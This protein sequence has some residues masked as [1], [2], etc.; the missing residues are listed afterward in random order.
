[1]IR[2]VLIDALPTIFALMLSGLYSVIDGLFIGRATGDIGLSAINIAWPITA[3]ITATGTGIGTGGSVLISNFSGKGLEKEKDETFCTTLSLLLISAISLMIV[4]LLTYKPLVSILGATGAVYNET[5]KYSGVIIA[6]SLLQI[7]GAGLL[8]MLRNMNMPFYAMCSMT[9]GMVVNIFVNYILIFKV[10]LGIEGAAYGTAIAQFVVL[11]LSFYFLYIK[12]KKRIDLNFN[13]SIASNILKIAVAAF[14][15]SIG[16]SIALI[17]TNKQCYLYGGNELL[18]CYAVISYIVFPVQFMLSG[19][20]DGTQPL[21]SY[22]YGA[23]RNE[24]LHQV[25]KI[26]I[27]LSIVISL[28]SFCLSSFMADSI[29]RWFG[30][31]LEAQKYFKEGMII[32]GISFF[33]LGF[34]KCKISFYN[35]TLQTKRATSLTYLECFFISPLCLLIL[36]YFIGISGIWITLTITAIIMLGIDKIFNIRKL[37]RDPKRCIEF[38]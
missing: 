14:G 19:V 17:F 13:I 30:L 29:G 9:V 22:F 12:G 23:N 32:S 36:P 34:M 3:V 10:G 6:S 28:L 20:G 4:L 1:M 27:A 8:P 24:E 26:A 5:I 16:P 31:S 21:L 38:N 15:I 2:R 25:Q 7:F 18:A 11:L 35:A 33:F 37:E